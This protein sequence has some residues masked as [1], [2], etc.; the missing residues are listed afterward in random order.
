MKSSLTENSNT[1]RRKPGLVTVKSAPGFTSFA[2]RSVGG[3][4][5]VEMPQRAVP[6]SVITMTARFSA[7]APGASVRSKVMRVPAPFTTGLVTTAPG[8]V[9]RTAPPAKFEPLT[10]IDVVAPDGTRPG[11]TSSMTGT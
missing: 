11:A 10:C 1:K 8:P 7:G 5:L 2:A 4:G 9:T 3:S 6:F